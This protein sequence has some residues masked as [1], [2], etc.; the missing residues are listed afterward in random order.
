QGFEYSVK[1]E[2]EESLRGALNTV[3][4][5]ID[6]YYLDRLAAE[7]GLRHEN[8]FPSSLEELVEKKYLRSIP[9][10]PVSAEASWEIILISETDKKVFDIKSRARGAALDNTLYSSW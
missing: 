2:K 5:A 10:D 7:P 8:R 3:R 1:K 9:L 6:R 4:S